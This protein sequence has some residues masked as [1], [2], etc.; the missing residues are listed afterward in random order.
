MTTSEAVDALGALLLIAPN[1]SRKA[2]GA[3]LSLGIDHHRLIEAVQ[4]CHGRS[5]SGNIILMK[6]GP[7]TGSHQW[8][9]ELYAPPTPEPKEEPAPANPPSIVFVPCAH[10]PRPGRFAA[11]FAALVAPGYVECRGFSESA[12]RRA[13]SQAN[14]RAGVKRYSVTRAAGVYRLWMLS[15]VGHERPDTAPQEER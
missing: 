14:K 11:H 5:S 12:V 4:E 1:Q 6:T 10:G 8:S 2:G 15:N 3:A 13:A 9:F 7:K